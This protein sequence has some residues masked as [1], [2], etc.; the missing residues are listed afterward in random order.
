MRTSDVRAAR[1]HRHPAAARG[2]AAA[3]AMVFVTGVTVVG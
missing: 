3:A 1:G 2:M